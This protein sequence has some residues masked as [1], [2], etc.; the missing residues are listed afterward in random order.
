VILG[1]HSSECDAT[2]FSGTAPK[3]SAPMY[4]VV[5]QCTVCGHVLYL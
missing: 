5:L 3:K 4:Y 2:I 1:P